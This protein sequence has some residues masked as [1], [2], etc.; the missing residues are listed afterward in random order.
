MSTTVYRIK[1]FAVKAL[2]VA[3]DFLLS[4]AEGILSDIVDEMEDEG[5]E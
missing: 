4:L 2:S 5:W 3:S 1:L